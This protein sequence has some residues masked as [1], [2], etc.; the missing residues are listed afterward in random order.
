MPSNQIPNYNSLKN[1]RAKHSNNV[2]IAYLN[3]N[4]VRNKFDQLK[5]YLGNTINILKIAETKL[6]ETFPDSQFKMPGMKKPYRLDISASSG[7][8]LVYVDT[9]ISSKRIFSSLLPDDIQVIILEINI[10]NQDC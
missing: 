5:E 4:S 2:S 9:N 8:L 7:G 3:I 6:D 1:L 10:K